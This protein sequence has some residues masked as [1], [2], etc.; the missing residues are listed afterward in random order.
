MRATVVVGSV[1]ELARVK[2]GRTPA[3]STLFTYD[4]YLGA[5]GGGR[6]TTG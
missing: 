5:D 3:H 2:R 1:A 4:V 6:F